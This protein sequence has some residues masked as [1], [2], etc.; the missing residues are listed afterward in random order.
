M[1]QARARDYY[2]SEY[3]SGNT[4][5]KVS[6]ERKQRV[7]TDRQVRTNSRATANEKALVMNAPYVLFLAAVSLVCLIMCVTYLHVQSQI[8]QTKETVAELK[9]EINTLQSQNDALQ[10][11]I[12]SNV[13]AEHIYK[14]AT[15]KLGMTQAVDD[16]ISMYQSS[17]SGYTVQYG[18]IPTE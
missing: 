5:R 11:S 2:R 3:V 4:V 9:T 16:Q 14:V 1:S 13:D 10:Y 7:Y 12:N 8:T 15:T 6:P 18:D 17:D